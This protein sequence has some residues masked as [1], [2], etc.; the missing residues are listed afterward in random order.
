MHR[1]RIYLLQMSMKMMLLDIKKIG[2]MTLILKITLTPLACALDI[3]SV[4]I[5]FVLSPV[6]SK[7]KLWESIR[8]DLSLSEVSEGL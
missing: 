4:L 3:N 2:L 1:I 5:L 8:R 7:T 6:G